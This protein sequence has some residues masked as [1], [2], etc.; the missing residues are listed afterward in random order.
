MA[1]DEKKQ[2]KKCSVQSADAITVLKTFV[3]TDMVIV[4]IF[5]NRDGGATFMFMDK[6]R[7]R[8]PI[9]FNAEGLRD[10]LKFGLEA[11]AENH[12]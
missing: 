4:D 8:Y 2:V 3:N 7:K 6:Q 12:E 1:K 11:I 5:Q 9:K 10:L